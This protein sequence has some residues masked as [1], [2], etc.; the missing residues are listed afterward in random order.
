M[1]GRLGGGGREKAPG[2]V[3]WNLRVQAPVWQVSGHRR[4][5]SWSN[6]QLGNRAPQSGLKSRQS[7]T[8]SSQVKSL[9][10]VKVARKT[11][12][13]Y[14]T[15]QVTHHVSSIRFKSSRLQ[16]KLKSDTWQN[17]LYIMSVKFTSSRVELAQESLPHQFTSNRQVSLTSQVKQSEMT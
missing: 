7:A 9:S 13:R 16:E 1:K 3:C 12:V 5:T 10:Q 6:P 2:C 17:K 4:A 11:K 15:K 14:V 8:K